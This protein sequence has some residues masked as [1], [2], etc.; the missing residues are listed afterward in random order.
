MW[1]P[2]KHGVQMIT[3]CMP[4]KLALFFSILN[5]LL[6]D[7]SHL[8]HTCTR[9]LRK[10]CM[11]FLSLA[12]GL[13]PLGSPEQSFLCSP[14]LGEALV[15]HSHRMLGPLSRPCPGTDHSGLLTCPPPHHT[16]SLARPW[17]HPWASLGYNGVSAY[18]WHSVNVG[19]T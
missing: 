19:C 10:P 11:P 16:M 4:L 15:H 8:S 18:S 9:V 7:K 1:S 5:S 14:G 12:S 6:D 13:P 3:D 2:S 17:D